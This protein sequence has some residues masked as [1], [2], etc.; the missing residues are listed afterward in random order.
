MKRAGAAAPCLDGGVAQVRRSACATHAAARL[1]SNRKTSPHAGTPA[2]PPVVS[3]RLGECRPARPEL[4]DAI[5][6]GGGKQYAAGSQQHR[7]ESNGAQQAWSGRVQ[8][9]D[10]AGWIFSSALITAMVIAP[11]S[12]ADTTKR[13]E[14][15]AQRRSGHPHA[16][17]Q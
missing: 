7:G 17:D 14:R 16:G 12:S 8:A 5:G 2:P 6:R 13:A 1:T 3:E 10:E 15:Y 11:S 4:F 9:A